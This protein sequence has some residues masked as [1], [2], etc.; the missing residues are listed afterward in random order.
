MPPAKFAAISVRVH[1]DLVRAWERKNYS[2]GI[3]RVLWCVGALIHVLSPIFFY[4][5]GFL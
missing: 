2:V 4:S 3:A 5:V 1:V